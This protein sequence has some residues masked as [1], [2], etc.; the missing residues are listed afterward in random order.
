[1]KNRNKR[2]GTAMI[3][4][5]CATLFF[6]FSFVYL[7]YYQADVLT[8]AQHVLS[9]GKTQY[10]RFVGA[11]LITLVLFL[12]QL[13]ISSVAMM[14]TYT[15]ALT[16]FPSMLA[17]AF[18]TSVGTSVDQ[19]VSFGS[20]VWVLPLLLLIF[21]VVCWLVKSF[22]FYEPSKVG[23]GFF[24]P[25]MWV[26][27]MVMFLMMLIV[28]GVGNADT[29]FHYRLKVERYLAQGK[30]G[31]ALQ[32]GRRSL[33]CDSSLMM[34]RA[35][36]MSRKGKLGD[37]LFQ[38]P[39]CGGADALLP[40]GNHVKT[41]LYDKQNIYAHLGKLVVTKNTP[42]RKYMATIKKHDLDKRPAAEYLLC[43]YLLDRK[44]D[45]FV[46]NVVK[47]YDLSE[48]LPRHYREA[49]TLY[50]YLHA[51]HPVKFDDEV[52][53]TD[54]QDYLKLEKQI[55]DKTKRVN[56]LRDVYG[57]TYWYYYWQRH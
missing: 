6:L 13:G 17:L 50:N 57:N 55:S 8:V 7:Y 34:L 10:S 26:N 44:L 45:D 20:W 38:Y 5:A 21:A 46:A 27:L 28:G 41:L 9:G 52:M 49:L 39:I 35:Y 15:H 30:Y 37:A 48:T 18:L 19:G 24:T 32:V 1:M 11:L 23:R 43:A 2:S 56:K 16:Y 3:R 25:P 12:L 36:A 51:Q 47:Y 33:V 4:V 31:T 29:P 42:F 14:T 53:D 22:G 40:D 54:Y